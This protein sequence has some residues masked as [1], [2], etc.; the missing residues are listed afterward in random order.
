MN[1]S[2]TSSRSL[3]TILAV[4]LLFTAFALT[5]LNALNLERKLGTSAKENYAKGYLAARKNYQSICALAGR[6]TTQLFG[7]VEF[8][9]GK[10]LRVLQQS[11]DTDSLVDGI[12]NLR[13]ISVTEATTIQ[14]VSKKSDEQFQKELEEFAK[15]KTP[16]LPPPSPVSYQTLRLSDI[17][18]G[19]RIF[20]QSSNDVRLQETINATLLRVL[21]E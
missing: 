12:S 21:E 5:G 15:L 13:T 20:I 14:R 8:N 16:K 7:K 18:I 3:L 11:L 1:T 4:I 9:D 6:E 10:V 17:P 2:N 19:A